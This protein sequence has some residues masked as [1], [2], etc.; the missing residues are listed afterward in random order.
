MPHTD[1]LTNDDHGA[2][3]SSD[4]RN[5][6][7]TGFMATGKSVV[8]ALLA[9]RLGFEWIDTDELIESRHGTIPEIFATRGENEFRRFE[10]EVA[11]EL[12]E[13]AGLVISTGGRMML[14]PENAGL[15]G[16]SGRVFCLV[17]SPD[18]IMQRVADSTHERPLLAVPDPRQ[19]IADLL[20]ERAEGYGRFPA[21]DTTGRSVAEVVDVIVALLADD[22]DRLSGC[23]RI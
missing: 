6:V 16:S 11:A 8:G 13:R 9:E 17:A 14:D 22:D 3:A 15:L 1:S 5:V 7:L 23:S 2:T 12:A 18:T 20:Q 19:R 21:V 10:R 4:R